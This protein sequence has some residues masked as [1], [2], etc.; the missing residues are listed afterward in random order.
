MALPI[1]HLGATRL[2]ANARLVLNYVATMAT[3]GRNIQAP[4]CQRK[5]PVQEL[6]DKIRPRRQPLSSQELKGKYTQ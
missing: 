3:L 2:V 1:L 6:S 5:D 4:Q